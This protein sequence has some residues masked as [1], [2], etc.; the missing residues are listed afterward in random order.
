MAKIKYRSGS[1]FVELFDTATISNI[2]TRLSTVEGSLNRHWAD[3]W[4]CEKRDDG[5]CTAVLTQSRTVNIAQS[6]TTDLFYEDLSAPAFPSGL[7]VKVYSVSVDIVYGNVTAWCASASNSSATTSAPQTVR[8]I[9][10]SS[11]NVKVTLRYNA[12][13]RWR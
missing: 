6:Y 1:S 11:G 4:L 3:S 5:F 10:P 12:L 7:F 2:Q 8:L 9:S 13:G